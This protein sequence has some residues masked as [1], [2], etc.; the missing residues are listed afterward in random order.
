MLETHARATVVRRLKEFGQTRLDLDW[1]ELDGETQTLIRENR[2]AFLIAVAFDR[3]MP[4]E[5][6]WRIPA[7]I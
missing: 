4:W 6:A 3:G 5:K 2:F 7:E 1:S